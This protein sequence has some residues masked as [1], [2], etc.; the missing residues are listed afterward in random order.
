MIY[1]LQERVF[2]LEEFKKMELKELYN[3]RSEV[4]DRIHWMLTTEWYD[5]DKFNRLTSNEKKINKII[6]KAELR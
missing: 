4:S 3:L 2:K 5:K 1:L 6:L